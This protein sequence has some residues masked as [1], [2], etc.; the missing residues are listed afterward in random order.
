MKNKE[1]E[2]IVNTV[3]DYYKEEQDTPITYRQI[4]ETLHKKDGFCFMYFEHRTEMIS[5]CIETVADRLIEKMAE[6][7]SQPGSVVGRFL[8]MNHEIEEHTSL[9]GRMNKGEDR[10][11]QD[12]SQLSRRQ[13]EIY[14]RLSEAIAGFIADGNAQAIFHVDSI[15]QK[16]TF[17]AY[18][19][20]GLRGCSNDEKSKTDIFYECMENVLGTDLRMYLKIAS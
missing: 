2:A 10:I 4:E 3:I 18:G 17:I 9:I 14:D 20:V 15:P 5:L 16:A 7:L 12:A 19:L 6:T 1:I 13:K 8:A 11:L